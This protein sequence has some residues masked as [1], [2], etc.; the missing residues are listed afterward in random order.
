[1]DLLNSSGDSDSVI[2]KRVKEHMREKMA[3]EAGQAQGDR[4]C[5]DC[6]SSLDQRYQASHL[7]RRGRGVPKEEAPKAEEPFSSACRAYGPQRRRRGRGDP[8]GPAK[9][10]KRNRTPPG[11]MKLN[12]AAMGAKQGGRV[13]AH[14]TAKKP[15]AVPETNLSASTW[16]ITFPRLV[17]QTTKKDK[18]RSDPEL[19]TKETKQFEVVDLDSPAPSPKKA[20]KSKEE[21][22]KKAKPASPKKAAKEPVKPK[23]RDERKPSSFENSKDV[24]LPGA[25]NRHQSTATH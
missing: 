20:K 13:S 6:R 3:Q 1:M 22:P 24:E 9:R 2:P 18:R 10:G 23:A 21:P 19:E 12:F 8:R 5:R 15:S 25:W 11:Q 16:M 7:L 4:G 17:E 14:V